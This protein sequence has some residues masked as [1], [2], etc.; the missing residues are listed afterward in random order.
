MLPIL[1][2][3]GDHSGSNQSNDPRKSDLLELG[4]S[5]CRPASLCNRHREEWLAKLT[6]AVCTSVR[7]S[8]IQQFD[9]L[10]GLRQQ[11]RHEPLVDS[12]KHPAVKLLRQVSST[13]LFAPICW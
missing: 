12:G 6:E 10:A 9:A 8:I 1:A 2:L 3:P 13:A 7:N 11:V 5:L 4:D